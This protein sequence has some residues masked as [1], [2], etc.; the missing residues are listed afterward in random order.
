MG[1]LWTI[2][3]WCLIGYGR[4]SFGSSRPIG[5]AQAG[6]ELATI[7]AVLEM[8]P[9]DARERYGATNRDDRLRAQQDASQLPIEVVQAHQRSSTPRQSDSTPTMKIPNRTEITHRLIGLDE[10][11][12]ALADEG[13]LP[14]EAIAYRFKLNSLD[15]RILML[16]AHAHGLVCTTHRAE[17]GITNR[18][19]NA[20]SPN[21]PGWTSRSPGDQPIQH[22][23]KWDRD[24]QK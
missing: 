9:Q 14:S 12:R 10:V 18:G 5:V 17:W 8:S 2:S 1:S 20:M 11:L 4:R 21:H 13:P 6:R 16:H 15:T 19:C 24:A 23:L 22:P 7:A 3:A